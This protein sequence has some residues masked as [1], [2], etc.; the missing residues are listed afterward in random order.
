MLRVLRCAASKLLEVL[1]GGH[2]TK[3]RGVNMAYAIKSS[4]VS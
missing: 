3:Y 4:Q 1:P 2:I